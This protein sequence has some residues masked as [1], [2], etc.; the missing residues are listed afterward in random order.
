M[1]MVNSGLKGLNSYTTTISLKHENIKDVRALIMLI[2]S[3][4]L[5]KMA[6]KMDI[7]ICLLI[8]VTYT[9]N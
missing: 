8:L 2:I 7:Y 6:S 5:D 1:T 3:V 9:V 4:Y